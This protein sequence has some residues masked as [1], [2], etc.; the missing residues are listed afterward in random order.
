MGGEDGGEGEALRRLGAPQP[1]AVDAA[2]N[3]AVTAALDA[4]GDGQG[5]DG[6][7]G[8]V[9][10][11]E[12]AVDDAC[13]DQRPGRVVDQDPLRGE[14]NE[15]FEA[16]ANRFL[17]L[18]AAFHRVEQIA[19]GHRGVIVFPVVG[20]YDDAHGI[21]R[22][23]GGKA[24]YHAAQKRLAAQRPILLGQAAAGARPAPGRHHQGCA[25][26]HLFHSRPHPGSITASE[27]GARVLFLTEPTQ[28]VARQRQLS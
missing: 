6:A 15:T 12:D 24:G 28:A 11:G 1:G 16:E 21:D 22:R 27:A 3:A 26:D 9:D 8:A 17:A 25:A 14:D 13:R 5:R 10:P 18:A 4:V 20:V 23:V 19:P 2:D 7:K